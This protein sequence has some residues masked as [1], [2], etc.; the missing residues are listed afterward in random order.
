M[1]VLVAGSRPEV[2]KLASVWRALDRARLEPK[3]LWTNQQPDM[4]STFESFDMWPEVTLNL[5]RESGSL[6]ELHALLSSG[7]DT[8][9]P[10]L[11][12]DW[13]IVQGDTL[14]AAVGAQQ[15]F[16]AG[17][18]VAHVEAG[19]RSW[20]VHSP[21]PEEACRVWIDQIAD[22]K[23]APTQG[24]AMTLSDEVY[25]TGNTVIDSLR[26]VRP[27]RLRRGRYAVVTMHRRENAD[28]VRDVCRAV[29]RILKVGAVDL[30][31]WPVHPNPIVS[32][33]VPSEMQGVPGCELIRPCR[34]D[35][36][37]NLIRW[38]QIVLTDSGGIQEECLALNVPCLVMRDETERPEGVQAGGA[39][40]VGTD[41]AKIANW[42]QWLMAQPEER[43]KMAEA[44]NPYGDGHA[45]SRIAAVM[46]A[47]LKGR[48]V[49]PDQI[50][51]SG[52]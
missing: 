22:V 2:I 39:I 17:I 49:D 12:P 11:R 1:I 20:N 13:M 52:P 7:F 31:V 46:T 10:T 18:P 14:S 24:A 33:V 28:G 9:L 42:T 26:W 6:T 44:R 16:L 35:Q 40:L 50:A 36:M 32:R 30:V 38:A 45:S 15:G 47:K 21:Y 34:Y 51:W 5:Q 4:L 43:R 29:R 41:P 48:T 23:F 25:V 19:L 37:V 8:V 3:W 27:Q